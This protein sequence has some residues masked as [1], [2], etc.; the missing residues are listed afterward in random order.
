MKSYF[1]YVKP[2]NLLDVFHPILNK[3][4]QLKAIAS[5]INKNMVST[6]KH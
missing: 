5:E 1:I 4:I 3:P 2:P 6:K